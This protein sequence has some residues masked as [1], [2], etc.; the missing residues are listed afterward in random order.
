MNTEQFC[1]TGMTCASCAAIIER[2]L[3]KIEGITS[4]QVNNRNWIIWPKIEKKIEPF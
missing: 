4:A 2:T 1:V 3:K